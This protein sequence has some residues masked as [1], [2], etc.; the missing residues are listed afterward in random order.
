MTDIDDL[1]QEFWAS[2]L[3]GLETSFIAMRSSRLLK[4]LRECLDSLEDNV[5]VCFDIISLF[6]DCCRLS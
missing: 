2:R 3:G 5:E 1:V 4:I 6:G